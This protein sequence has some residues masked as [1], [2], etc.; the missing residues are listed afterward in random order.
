VLHPEQGQALEPKAR[1]APRVSRLT[2]WRMFGK[3]DPSTSTPD[4]GVLQGFRKG[5]D[6]RI[7]SSLHRN[8]PAYRVCHEAV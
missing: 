8:P 6:T 1:E 7:P 2:P 5:A 3:V 4:I